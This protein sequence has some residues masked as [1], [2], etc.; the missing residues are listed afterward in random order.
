M[1][2]SNIS[3]S[4]TIDT[5]SRES[6]NNYEDIFPTISSIPNPIPTSMNQDSLDSKD[7][8]EKKPHST[9]QAFI[10]SSTEITEFE[11]D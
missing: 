2:T 6:N 10:N 11:N 4:N 1:L 3:S 8:K 5:I 9:S 7:S